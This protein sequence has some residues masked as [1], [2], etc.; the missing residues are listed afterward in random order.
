MDQQII[1]RVL[2]TGDLAGLTPDQRL[3]YYKSVCESL[4]LNPLTQPFGYITFE[5]RLQLYA[6]KDATEQLRKIHNVSITELKAD[7]RDNVYMVTVKAQDIHGRTDMAT[8]AVSTTYTTD[9]GV[10]KQYMGTGL[11][12]AIMKAET[13][14]KRRVT[15]SICGLGLLDESEV[16]DLDQR[17][18]QERLTNGNDVIRRNMEQATANVEGTGT[19]EQTAKFDAATKPPN[20]NGDLGDTVVHIGKAEGNMLGRKVSELPDAIITWLHDKWR[21]RLNPINATDQ[22]L[23]L[24]KA[25]EAE[26]IKRRAASTIVPES[27]GASPPSPD[28]TPPPNGVNRTALGEW[29]RDKVE[30]LAMTPK[31]FCGYLQLAGFG[32][33]CSTLEELTDQQ[34]Q[35]LHAHW[36]ESKA[37]VEAAVK[38]PVTESATPKRKKGRGRAL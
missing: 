34:L 35:Y 20:G 36:D 13:K 18:P 10:V 14:A 19:P 12:N 28:T 15:L 27:P 16:E 4:G 33:T 1:E 38:P 9:N 17:P 5:G 2:L 30:D 31:Q 37:M 32:N 8:G 25:V 26:A 23:K 21:D 24:K 7:S 22:D 6:R 29:L 11:A 3:A